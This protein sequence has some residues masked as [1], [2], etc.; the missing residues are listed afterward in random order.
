MLD[1]KNN[2]INSK[3][4]WSQHLVTLL[5]SSQS[6]N[7]KFLNYD[8]YTNLCGEDVQKK[9]KVLGNNV[10]TVWFV[11]Q[12]LKKEKQN[13]KEFFNNVYHKSFGD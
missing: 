10:G 4:V 1:W 2:I 13:K 9:K 3:S 11:P 7:L 8:F 6:L 12:T 5:N